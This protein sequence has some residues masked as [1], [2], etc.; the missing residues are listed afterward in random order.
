MSYPSTITMPSSTNTSTPNAAAPAKVNHKV[1][2]DPANLAKTLGTRPPLRG[3]TA[4]LLP[5]PG[6]AAAPPAAVPATPPP[7]TA[8][9]IDERDVQIARL[10]AAL[11]LSEAR[12]TDLQPKSKSKK[13]G[14]KKPVEV[15]AADSVAENAHRLTEKWDKE[16]QKRQKKEM[17]KR[18]RDVT[19]TAP[20][21]MPDRADAP[22][23][24]YKQ[25]PVVALQQEV[26]RELNEQWSQITSS[27]DRSSQSPKK[28]NT[29]PLKSYNPR[30]DI[31]QKYLLVDFKIKEDGDGAPSQRTVDNLKGM[32]RLLCCNLT[33]ETLKRYE[34]A[35]YATRYSR[36]AAVKSS[37]DSR[38]SVAQMAMICEKIKEYSSNQ[39]IC[40][41]HGGYEI[42]IIWCR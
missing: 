26:R 8:V 29:A 11:Q 27:S 12:V 39:P 17:S 24:V 34:A 30:L 41:P 38:W 20:E 22:R 2:C 5:S 21:E 37:L 10:Q 13:K 32:F 4:G 40:V 7:A 36:A 28:A 15:S 31:N 1:P 9:P 14:Y 19:L 33:R 6:S 25:D 35:V 16:K 42:P 3:N 18:R 23:R